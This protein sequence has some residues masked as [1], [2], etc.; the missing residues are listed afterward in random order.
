MDQHVVLLCGGRLIYDQLQVL[1][2]HQCYLESKTT[3]YCRDVERMTYNLH[4]LYFDVHLDGMKMWPY[5]RQF[6]RSRHRWQHSPG[7]V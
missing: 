1:A 2:I 4:S 6:A 3:V 7:E 5:Q